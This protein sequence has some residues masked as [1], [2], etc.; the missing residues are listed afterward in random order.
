[1]TR[2]SECDGPLESGSLLVASLVHW[3]EEPKV[4]LSSPLV[5]EG[6]VW[7]GTYAGRPSPFRAF[8]CVR[9]QRCIVPGVE[10]CSHTRY[11]G[12]IFLYA[13]LRWVSGEATFIPTFLYPFSARGRNG[14]GAETLSSPGF[15][16]SISEARCPARRCSKCGSLEIT[17]GRKDSS[18]QRWA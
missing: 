6:A 16:T 1:M 2:C 11:P 13:K 15:P 18:E 8:R 7:H 4:R 12:W 3:S 17:Y 10:G 9:C 14:V 5:L